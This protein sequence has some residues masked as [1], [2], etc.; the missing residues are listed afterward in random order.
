MSPSSSL[1]FLGS[2]VRARLLFPVPAH[3]SRS[4]SMEK[5]L[6]DFAVAERGMI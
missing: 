4:F 1:V 5:S 2:P 6:S 3:T